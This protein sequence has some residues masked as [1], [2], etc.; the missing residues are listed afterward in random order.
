MTLVSDLQYLAPVPFYYELSTSSNCIFEQYERYQKMSF[1]NRCT[2]SGANG[3]VHLSIPIKGGREQNALMKDVVIDNS[4]KWQLRHWRTITSAYNKSPWLDFYRDELERI[5]S[6]RFELLMDWNLTCF[7]WSAD[8]LAIRTPVSLSEKYIA[9][10]PVTECKDWRNRLLPSTINQLYP[11]PERYPQ[12]FEDRF[13]FLP[14][15]SILDKLFCD[16]GRL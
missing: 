1:R 7:K 3:P 12:V 8:K 11:C 15:L 2:L 4:Q 14:N 13:G 6:T 5:F 9:D 16:G 10:Y